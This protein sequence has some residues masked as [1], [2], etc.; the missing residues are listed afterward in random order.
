MPISGILVIFPLHIAKRTAEKA[1]KAIDGTPKPSAR[2][3]PSPPVI[4]NAKSVIPM[5]KKIIG[6]TANFNQHRKSLTYFFTLCF[7]SFVL[8]ILY[9]VKSSHR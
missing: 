7:S 4:P 1:N 5:P 2:P 3:S 9:L 6:K 8:S